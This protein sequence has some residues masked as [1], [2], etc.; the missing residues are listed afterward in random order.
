[1]EKNT[2]FDGNPEFPIGMAYVPWQ[3]FE[4]LYEPDVAFSR[5]T[6]FAK[7]DLPFLGKAGVK[8]GSK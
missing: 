8:H 3:K 2:A 5:G 7:L 6:L 4:N 1:M